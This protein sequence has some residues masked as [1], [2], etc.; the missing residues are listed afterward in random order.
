MLCRLLQLLDADVFVRDVHSLVLQLFHIRGGGW[1][2]L[3]I[4]PG[5]IVGGNAALNVL[6]NA[7]SPIVGYWLMLLS[8][9]EDSPR[10]SIAC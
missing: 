4:L 6:S 5:L 8:E 2:G 1:D 7:L 3:E 9:E 10:M